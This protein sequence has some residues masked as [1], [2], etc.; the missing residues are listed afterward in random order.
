VGKA[1][2][3][4]HRSRGGQAEVVDEILPQD[5]HGH[6]V[7]QERALPGETDDASGRVQF[8]ELLVMQILGAHRTPPS[9]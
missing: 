2:R 1:E 6:G 9:H 5:P 4:Q 7:E 8:Q 3:G